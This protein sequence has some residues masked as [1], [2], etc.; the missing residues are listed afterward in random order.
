MKH[1]IT[2]PN[3]WKDYGYKYYGKIISTHQTRSKYPILN[4][5]FI[6][7]L[8][9]N[10]SNYIIVIGDSIS[11]GKFGRTKNMVSRMLGYKNRGGNRTQD[12]IQN[13]LYDVMLEAFKN[14]IKVEIWVRQTKETGFEMINEIRMNHL[15]DV[16][17][18]EKSCAEK[19]KE[20]EGKY[21][22]HYNPK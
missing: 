21:P 14:N 16:E 22:K 7:D 11:L 2:S 9:P 20:I 18:F 5:E 19:Y 8:L 6:H 3:Y 17:G 10:P 1:K 15:P 4:W 13:S 12:R